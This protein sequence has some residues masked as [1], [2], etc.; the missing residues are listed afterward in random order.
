MAIQRTIQ[1]NSH[2][3]TTQRLDLEASGKL[4]IHMLLIA[5]RSRLMNS[6]F[7]SHIIQIISAAD[8]IWGVKVR[9]TQE[10]SMSPTEI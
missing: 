2:T 9:G 4:A 5:Q 1:D 6:I 8:S 7:I 10:N 3:Y